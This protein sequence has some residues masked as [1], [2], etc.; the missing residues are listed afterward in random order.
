[1][2][3]HFRVAGTADNALCGADEGQ[4]DHRISRVTCAACKAARRAQIKR[5][6]A[7]R[8]AIVIPAWIKGAK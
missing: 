4:T 5:E 3:L 2:G 7:E 1:M 8:D 6:Q